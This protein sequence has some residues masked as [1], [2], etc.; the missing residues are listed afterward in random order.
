MCK[1]NIKISIRSLKKE[2]RSALKQ[3]VGKELGCEIGKNHNY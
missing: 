1:A 2:R 3:W